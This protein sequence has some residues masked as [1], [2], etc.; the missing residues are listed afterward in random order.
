MLLFGEEFISSC[1]STSLDESGIGEPFGGWSSLELL[2]VLV[3]RDT[4]D[5]LENE[6]REIVTIGVDLSTSTVL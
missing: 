4:F 1:Q 6:W 3:D 2:S 5:R